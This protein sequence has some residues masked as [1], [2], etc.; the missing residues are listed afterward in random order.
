MKRAPLIALLAVGLFA[1]VF[2]TAC[3]SDNR[4]VSANDV[5]VVGDEPISK[6]QFDA[7]LDRARENYARNKQEFPA[8]GT[9]QYV[10]LRRQ[11]MQFLVQ[12]AQF[13]QKAKEL[14]LEITESDVD[15]QMLTIKSQYF[16]KNGKCDA[17]CETKYAAEIKK[18]GVTDEQVR[19]DV[20]ASV[21]QNKIYEKVTKDVTVT[22]KDVEEYYKKNKQ[23]YVQPASR[24]VRH[25]LVKKKALAE[26]LYQRVKNGENFAA[27]AKK[28]SEDPSSKKQGGKLPISKGR[29]VPEFDKA[30][31]AL[32]VGE[33]SRP[34][35]TTY[36]WHIITALTP[37][38]KAKTTPLSEV[39]PAIRQQLLQQKKTEAMKGWVEET[40]K[41]FEEKTTYQVGYE[42]PASTNATST[43]K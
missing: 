43:T 14:G 16:G 12:R 17:A 26:S 37:I 15:K 21:V 40:Q 20:R 7:L 4:S 38:K 1:A 11:A 23:N 28:F 9:A 32:D 6:E 2:A 35:K 31:F 30:A 27:L 5:A 18:Q 42:P 34:V 3:G 25:I 10:A 41:N 33:I 29:Q 8:A 19:E 22:D 13:E 24:D 39:R 36:G